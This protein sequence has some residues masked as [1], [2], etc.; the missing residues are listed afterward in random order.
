[1][2]GADDRHGTLARLTMES[3]LHHALERG[4][5]FL[6][7]RPQV[8]LGSGAVTCV[9]A[10]LRWE[11]DGRGRV[12]PAEFAPLLEENGLIV[13][14]GNWVLRT[15]CG[16]CR[17]WRDEGLDD[18]RVGVNVSQ[19]RLYQGDLD[20]TL[21]FVLGAAGGGSGPPLLEIEITES[22]LARDLDLLVAALAEL[23]AAPVRGGGGALGT[24]AAALGARGGGPAAGVKID[25][26]FVAG[27][28][29][30]RRARVL[31]QAVVTLGKGLGMEVVAEGVETPRQLEILREMG[32]DAAQGYL[33]ARPLPVGEVAAFVRDHRP[34]G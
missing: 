26:A 5:L 22:F 25:R 16:Q 8:A 1:M 24:G 10:L 9:E 23:P 34:P 32:C 30:D 27:V 20:T 29:A 33:L 31:A 15:A 2:E 12:G 13:A 21:G 19:R 4:E 14:V 3:D 7:Y 11:R 18:M 17:D 6:E 28:D